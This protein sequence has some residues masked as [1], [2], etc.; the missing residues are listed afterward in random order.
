MSETIPGGCYIG[1]DGQAHDAHGNVLASKP[2]DVPPAAVETPG[3]IGPVSE[4]VSEAA[5]VTMP[6]ARKAKRG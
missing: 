3:P 2:A 6:A 1:T 5:V 4:T